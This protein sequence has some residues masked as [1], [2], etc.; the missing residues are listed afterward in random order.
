MVEYIELKELEK[1]AYKTTFQDGLWDIYI[2]LLVLGW[3][4]SS[5]GT[6]LEV[7]YVMIIVII[8]YS[9]TFLIFYFGKK[10]ITVPRMGL[11]KF[12][13]KRKADKKKLMI[14]TSIN[15]II[16]M[17]IFLLRF[18]GIFQY[19]QLDIYVFYFI[20]IVCF[21][22]F[23]FSMVA[24]FLKFYR[25]FLYAIMGG[26]SF[27][28]SELIYPLIGSPLNNL[29]PFSIS[30]VIIIIIGINY[31]ILFLKKYPLSKREEIN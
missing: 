12:G 22:W 15:T 19:F 11:V 18:T 5:F 24:Y 31:F 9:I 14:F 7:L 10:Y 6:F 21:V 28:I 20:I 1:R 4:I 27:I 29:I 23:P 30:G 2:G 26:S 8:W 17:I 13:P 25:L 3:N 16:L